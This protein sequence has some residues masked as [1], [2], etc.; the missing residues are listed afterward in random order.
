MVKEQQ[1]AVPQRGRQFVDYDLAQH[2]T[3]TT[4]S[5]GSSFVGKAVVLNRLHHRS[6]T[7]VYHLRQKLSVLR[8]KKLR[9]HGFLNRSREP[10]YDFR[11]TLISLLLTRE[12]LVGFFRDGDGLEAQ[13]SV[14]RQHTI[15]TRYRLRKGDSRIALVNASGWRQWWSRQGEGDSNSNVLRKCLGI[16]GLVH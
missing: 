2:G 11:K 14:T 7:E 12:H 9:P 1:T 3:A 13:G 15:I 4:W 5:S 8:W 16:L 6:A 10:L